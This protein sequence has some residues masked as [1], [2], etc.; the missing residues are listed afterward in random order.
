[1]VFLWRQSLMD[2]AASILFTWCVAVTKL[3]KQGICDLSYCMAFLD[4]K[5]SE[6]SQSSF[7]Y[8]FLLLFGFLC[9]TTAKAWQL[10][11]YLN[12]QFFDTCRVSLTYFLEYKIDFRIH[13]RHIELIILM[14]STKFVWQRCHTR[15]QLTYPR[16]IISLLLLSINYSY[17]PILVV[18][19]SHKFW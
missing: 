1:M 12:I 18:V 8:Y 14:V 9:F 3:H 4:C 7:Y 10:M 19:L 5:V 13:L 2:T 16:C 6:M 15:S 17:C 11:V